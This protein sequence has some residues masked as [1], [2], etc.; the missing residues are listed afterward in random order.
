MIYVGSQDAC[1]AYFP[2]LHDEFNNFDKY[3]LSIML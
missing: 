1:V 2:R 3:E